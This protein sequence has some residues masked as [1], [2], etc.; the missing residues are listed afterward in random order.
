VAPSFSI[1]D[2]PDAL[3]HLPL[4]RL[5]AAI[6]RSWDSRTAYLGVFEAGNPALGQCYPTSRVV[7]WF[8]PRFEIASGSVDTGTAL[9]HHFWNVDPA[10]DPP[11][12]VD[13]TWR[14]F[15]EGSKVTR[16]T[17]LDR[18]G[19]NDSPPTIARCQLLLDRV[20]ARLEH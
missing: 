20:L 7:Q 4:N 11:V 18:H 19:S 8:F 10:A 14:Q 5:G 17:L 13:L 6:E 2:P 12:L 16:F 15:P 1:S 9:E 3:R